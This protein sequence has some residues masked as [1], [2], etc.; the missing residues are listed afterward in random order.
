MGFSVTSHPLGFG[1]VVAGAEPK[2]LEAPETT[3]VQGA[4]RPL[5]L[6]DHHDEGRVDER[7]G[8]ERT[9]AVSASATDLPI[10]AVKRVSRSCLVNSWLPCIALPF[11]VGD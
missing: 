1:L 10:I 6:K 9:P 5:L 7:Y 11:R 3:E 2:G 8:E 4:V